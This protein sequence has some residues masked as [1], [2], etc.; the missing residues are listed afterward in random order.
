MDKKISRYIVIFLP[1]VSLLTTLG[2]VQI[3]QLLK[4]KQLQIIFLIAVILL[5][6]A[7]VLRLNPYYRA[8]YYPLLSG[9]WV[10]EN[11]S[12]ITGAGLDLAADYLNALPNAEHLK[13]R[14]SLFS[15]DLEYYLVGKT[16]PP[17]GPNHDY[18]GDF[19]Y[20][21]EHLYDKQ[22]QGTPVDPSPID[23]IQTSKRQPSAKYNRELEQVIRLNGIDYVWI[24]RILSEETP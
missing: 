8:Y 13:I 14:V 21:V 10:S 12:S 19:D 24:Y 18:I 22:I 15:R 3:A 9:K 17:F 7:P 16:L 1:A 23:N 20:D 5:Q 4:K 11:T 2:A 6:L